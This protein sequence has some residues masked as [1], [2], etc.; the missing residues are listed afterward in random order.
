MLS[1]KE[2]WC[3]ESQYLSGYGDYHCMS[4]AD[5]AVKKVT[6]YDHRAVRTRTGEHFDN[7]L[8]YS[9]EH[10]FFESGVAAIQLE[11]RERSERFSTWIHTPL[12]P[13]SQ[14]KMKEPKIMQTKKPLF[15]LSISL[16]LNIDRYENCA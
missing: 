1:A 9:Y 2:E 13:N 15:N 3:R 8:P 16:W 5:M 4:Y 10:L 11:V 7:Y 6:H 12:S 14:L